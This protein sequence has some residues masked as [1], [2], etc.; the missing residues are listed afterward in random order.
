MPL[1]PDARRKLRGIALSLMCACGTSPAPPQQPARLA[2][3]T[4]ALATPDARV[5]DGSCPKRTHPPNATQLLAMP[6]GCITEVDD[7]VHYWAIDKSKQFAPYESKYLAEQAGIELSKLIR[8]RGAEGHQIFVRNL[9]SA[10]SQVRTVCVW[11]LASF[12][13]AADIPA[14]AL[15][16][17]DVSSEVRTAA[18]AALATYGKRTPLDALRNVFANETEWSTRY[19][20]LEAL[21][22]LGDSDHLIDVLREQMTTALRP[23]AI[24]L[25]VFLRKSPRVTAILLAELSRNLAKRVG[26]DRISRHEGELVN[27]HFEGRWI[28]TPSDNELLIDAL[29]ELQARGAVPLLNKLLALDDERRGL[30]AENVAFA[31]HS[32]TKKPVR[33]R[34]LGVYKTYPASSQT[35]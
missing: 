27:G 32:L 34:E 8:A 2:V 1:P 23:Q 18:V 10:S 5:A 3:A 19:T 16:L 30:S 6:I 35:P 11:G 15:R 21:H 12:E 13:D 26:H 4:A 31:I 20:A 25:L 7:I 9:M 14:I 28:V 22:R 33:Y 24:Q 17:T 29:V